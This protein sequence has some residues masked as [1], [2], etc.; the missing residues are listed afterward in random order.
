MPF[1]QFLLEL[2]DDVTP[3]QAQQR[4]DDYRADFWGSE[5]EGSTSAVSS[6]Y[7]SRGTVALLT[8]KRQN[9]ASE[10]VLPVTSDGWAM[11]RVHAKLVVRVKS[12]LM[13]AIL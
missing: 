1:K 13:S 5:V 4:Y 8:L 7:P 12:G 9:P 2:P 11:R 3:E 10:E 6:C